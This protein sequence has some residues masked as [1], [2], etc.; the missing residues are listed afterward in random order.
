MTCVHLKNW[1]HRSI[2]QFMVAGIIACTLLATTSHAKEPIP[3]HIQAHRGAGE[4]FPENTLESFQWSWKHGVT[5]ESDLRTTKDGTIVCFHDPNLKRV[6]Y[7][8]ND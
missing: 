5:P 2:R 7:K 6:P 8:I 1:L 4:A 3:F